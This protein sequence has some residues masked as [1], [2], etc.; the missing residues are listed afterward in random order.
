MGRETTAWKVAQQ[1]RRGRCG[2]QLTHKWLKSAG[3]KVDTE[4]L[5]VA[6][7]YQSLATRSYQHRILNQD[8][9]PMCR[10]CDHYE[11]T[12]DHFTSSCPEQCTHR[13][14]KTASY[15]HQ[16]ICKYNIKVADKWYEHTPE[17]RRHVLSSETCQSTLIKKSNP[18]GLT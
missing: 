17:K 3:L 11:E 7:E 1:S 18:T 14:N 15:I 16:S 10:V 8:V 6:A 4:G 5:L 2:L 9:N 12:I 13:H